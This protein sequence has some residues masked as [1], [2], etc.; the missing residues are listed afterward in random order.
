MV[1]NPPMIAF[2]SGYGPS[3][4]LPSV[5]TMLALWLATPPPKIPA[6][7]CDSTVRVGVS[8]QRERF[9]SLPR[10]MAM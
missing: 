8:A 9:T 2:V 6:G 4:T 1:A 7:R 10:S 5:P 3:V